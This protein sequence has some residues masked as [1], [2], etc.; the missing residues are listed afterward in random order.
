[1]YTIKV[2]YVAFCVNAKCDNSSILQ[3]LGAEQFAIHWEQVHLA[4]WPPDAPIQITHNQLV[5]YSGCPGEA[6]Q[7]K[8]GRGEDVRWDDYKVVG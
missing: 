2:Y 6:G 7:R 4:T 5:I 3:H 1:M 8:V